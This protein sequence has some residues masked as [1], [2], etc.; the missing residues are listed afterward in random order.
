MFGVLLV[1]KQGIVFALYVR[2]KYIALIKK[3]RKKVVAVFPQVTPS[4]TVGPNM[5]MFNLCLS[6]LENSY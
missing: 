4:S 5:K 6:S 1:L 3:E 2:A